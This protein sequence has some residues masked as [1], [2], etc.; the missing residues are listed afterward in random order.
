MKLTK[1]ERVELIF[2]SGRVGW[3]Y[4]QV[5]EAFN[6]SHN[7]RPPISRSTVSKLVRKFQETGSVN[8]KPH[9]GRHPI[10]E[11]V[12][13]AVMAKVIVAPIK[14]VRQTSNELG[15]SRCSVHRVL[16]EN[17]F[18]PYKSQTLQHLRENDFDRRLEM[19][20]W[21][22]NE[23]TNNANFS[24]D[25]VMFSDEAIFHVNGQVN[26]QNKRFWSQTNP[27][28]VLPTAQQGTPKVMVWCGLWR[29]HVLGP[30]FLDGNVTGD[31]YLAMLGDQLIPSIDLLQEERP[32]WF[33]QDG[34]PPHFALQVR[35]WL[36]ANFNNWI[37]RIGTVEWAPRSPDL[38]P[39]DFFFWGTLKAQVYSEPIRDIDHL[40]ERII[41]GC[42]NINGDNELITRVHRNFVHRLE[43][44]I[45]NE[46]QHIEHVI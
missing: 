29:A 24:K 38:N 21:F 44:C 37:G 12:I 7:D 25:S 30:F 6:A 27:H 45:A 42:L 28:F 17:K 20:N 32:A 4:R 9:T 36:D 31:T 14:S 13:E 16:K 46:G 19:C 43:L 11:E 35:N 41:E 15:V 26:K 8:D 33:Q 5:A 34:A 10:G 40:K 23:I 22:L 1:D 2:F 18:H 3:S 39:L